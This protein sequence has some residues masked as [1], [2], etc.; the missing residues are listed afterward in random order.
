MDGEERGLE[1]G[2]M[3][4]MGG[5]RS[6]DA[7]YATLQP[8]VLASGSPRR[9]RLLE[10]VGLRFQVES[11]RVSEEGEPAGPD[12]VKSAENWA[13]KKARAVSLQF[14]ESWVLSAD[15]IVVLDKESFGKPAGAGDARR[16]LERL[17]GRT[18]EVITGV[19]LVRDAPAF[20]RAGS[21]VTQVTFK[22][23]SGSEIRA[24]IATGEPLDKAGAYGIQGRGACLVRS[25]AGSYTNVVGLPL[26]ETLEWLLEQGVIAPAA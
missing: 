24:Y 17:S 22:E 25:I 3:Q 19:C 20:C 16:M 5:G 11:S 15:T 9:K 7:L 26:C 8:L 6:H 12:P 23:L 18:H 10:S 2:R 4:V 1:A 14:P 21:V 13:L